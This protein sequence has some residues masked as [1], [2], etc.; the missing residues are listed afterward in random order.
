MEFGDGA[1]AVEYGAVHGALSMTTPGDTTMA[2]LAGRGD[3]S[4]TRTAPRT[5]VPARER[6]SLSLS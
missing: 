6:P 1:K 5:A 4:P 3:A 2:T